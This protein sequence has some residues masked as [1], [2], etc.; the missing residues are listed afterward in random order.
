MEVYT[1]ESELN[2]CLSHLSAA[3]GCDVQ[4]YCLQMKAGGRIGIKL[5][6][7]IE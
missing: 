2:H 1:A 6:E 5:L 7:P 4:P 3:D